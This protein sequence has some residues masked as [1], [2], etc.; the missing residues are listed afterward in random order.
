ML[1]AYVHDAGFEHKQMW[2]LIHVKNFLRQMQ[3]LISV[4]VVGICSSA[5]V[6]CTFCFGYACDNN[7]DYDVQRRW[8]L[9]VQW[10][11]MSKFELVR[12]EEQVWTCQHLVRRWSWCDDWL[13]LNDPLPS[14][15][16][17]QALFLFLIGLVRRE[18]ANCFA[19]TPPKTR[20]LHLS[21]LFYLIKVL[22]T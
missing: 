7:L 18:S 2:L 9:L 3:R 14:Q 13:Q 5:L 11:T 1:T 15:L 17:F 4:N 16:Y 19:N 6:F 10:S 22:R 21:T 20:W 12:P 8:V